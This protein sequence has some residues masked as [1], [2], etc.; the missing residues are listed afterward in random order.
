MD[1]DEGLDG[2]IG[3]AVVGGVEVAEGLFINEGEGMGAEGVGPGALEALAFF[4]GEEEG[5][6][7]H[8]ELRV[9]ASEHGRFLILKEQGYAD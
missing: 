4:V 2:G 8:G 1:G 5:G 9:L 7:E 3:S 6:L